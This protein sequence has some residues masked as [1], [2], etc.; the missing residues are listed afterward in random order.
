MNCCFTRIEPLDWQVKDF[1]EKEEHPQ[2]RLYLFF[3]VEFS[4]IIRFQI[5]QFF[6][7]FRLAATQGDTFTCFMEVC[8]CSLE[9]GPGINSSAIPELSSSILLIIIDAH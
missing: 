8:Y 5:S 7:S 6:Q 9:N 2:R 4:E 3:E 1:K